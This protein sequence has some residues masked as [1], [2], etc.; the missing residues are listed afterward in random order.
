M[1]VIIFLFFSFISLNGIYG[2]EKLKDTLPLKNGKVTYTN[3][4]VVDGIS[5][6]ELYNRAIRW[7]AYTYET[8]KIDTKDEL[9]ARGYILPAN[10]KGYLSSDQPECVWQTITIRIKDGIYK[11][12]ITD[13][14]V[15]ISYVVNG[16]SSNYD[17][18]LETYGNK[19]YYENVDIQIKKLIAS[20]DKALK[21]PIDDNW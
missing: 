3:D 21:I 17:S 18:A 7:L 5:K 13:F 4:V 10:G 16:L 6:D 1:K 11:Y 2:Q 14:F 12:E 8:V 20:L 19:K 9:V 15:K